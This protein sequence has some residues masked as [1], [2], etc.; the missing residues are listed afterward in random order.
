MAAF[1]FEYFENQFS[2]PD[3]VKAH[4]GLPCLGL[5]PRLGPRDLSCEPL[6]NN[7]VP[8]LFSEAF[9]TVRTNVLFSSA[10]LGQEEEAV[11]SILVTSTEPNEGKT[12]IASNLAVG[13]AMTGQRVLLVDA[14]MRKPRLHDIFHQDL[15]PGLSSLVMGSAKASEAIRPADP[16]VSG[17]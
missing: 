5:V 16:P 11:K 1:F 6:V 3:D 9:R 10:G 4:L 15:Q 14:D 12:L 7:G 17:C 8:A 2:S 13:L